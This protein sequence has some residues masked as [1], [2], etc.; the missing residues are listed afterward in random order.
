MASK[1]EKEYM[2]RKRELETNLEAEKAQYSEKLKKL[3]RNLGK[4]NVIHACLYFLSQYP[5]MLSF[6]QESKQKK[7]A[8]EEV[9][10]PVFNSCVAGL[11]DNETNKCLEF[12]IPLRDGGNR[13]EE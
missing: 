5:G 13:A 4:A 9:R 6:A 12:D 2:D 1:A 8:T 10:I 7:G 11:V 3:V